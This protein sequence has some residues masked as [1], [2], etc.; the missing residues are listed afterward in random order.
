MTRRG[1]R[2]HIFPITETRLLV[3]PLTYRKSIEF[4]PKM[5][6]LDVLRRIFGFVTNV[7]I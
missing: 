6:Y 3:S 7:R 5:L 1:R 4:M 2:R